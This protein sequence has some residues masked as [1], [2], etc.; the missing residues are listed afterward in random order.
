MATGAP[1]M[2]DIAGVPDDVLRAF[3]TR[4]Q[5][6]ET[7]LAEHDEA[8]PR[9]AQ[10]AALLTRR[11][12]DPTADPTS[13]VPAWRAKARALGFDADTIERLTGRVQPQPAPRPGSLEADAL[14]RDLAS[15]GGLTAHRST[16][17]RPDVIE[18]ICERLPA[19]GRVED[20]LA[21]ADGF[22]TS[23]RVLAVGVDADRRFHRGD[24]RA[25]PAGGAL[26]RWT[27]PEM[28]DC[29][30]QVLDLATRDRR[31]AA[32]YVCDETVTRAV[33][34]R[35]TLTAEQS[36]M[37]R[38]VCGSGRAV[39]V[40]EGVAGAGKTFALAVAHDAWTS[41]GYRV[42]GACLAARAARNLHDGAGIASTT[43]DRLLARIEHGD[44]LGVRDVVVVDEASMVGTRKL[45]RLLTAAHVAGA[46]VVLVG[47][48]R[49]LPEVEAGGAF[50]HL[51][52]QLGVPALID[53]RRQCEGWERHA[54]ATLRGGD[55]DEALAMYDARDR[56]HAG[57]SD[58][59]VRDQ[60]VADWLAAR[61]R[62][63]EVLMIASRLRDVDDLNSRA[64]TLLHRSG[65][66]GAAVAVIGGR[67]FAIGEQVLA[68]RN[69]HASGVLNGTRGTLRSVG[70]DS[71]S[72]AADG[73]R[74]TVPRHYAEAGHLA[75]GYAT[76]IHKAQ[77]TTVD[78]C[79]VLADDTLAQEHAY[80]AMSRG[81]LG[82]DLYVT[83]TDRRVDD[84]HAPEVTP[85]PLESLRAAIRRS[86]AERFAIDQPT[87]PPPSSIEA[88][89]AERDHLRAR[90]A[91][92]LADPTAKVEALDARV[93]QARQVLAAATSQRDQLAAVA[94]GG[95][96][97]RRL[98]R[99]SVAEAAARLP[100]AEKVVR[101]ATDGLAG[102]TASRAALEPLVRVW[103][104]DSVERVADQDRL[105]HLEL[106][107]R[108]AQPRAPGLE[109]SRGRGGGLAIGL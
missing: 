28:V 2:A 73:R 106:A 12:K 47:D 40:V 62:G 54:L 10:R 20:V 8:G 16:F 68:L 33:D 86:S 43:L 13:M 75:H 60:L 65:Q 109:R 53:N 99:Q 50:A 61:E 51:A 24:G 26:A 88:L 30:R 45:L 44:G 9:A 38:H 97:A 14:Y 87:E 108:L 49:Q 67:P 32:G 34:A 102:L 91:A 107:L 79:L 22:L 89:H 83:A 46:K 90:L 52:H 96:L 58:D 95:R 104:E 77:G 63:E 82:N 85:D 101:D 1:G 35:T 80:T 18:A 7:Y 69:D 76:T 74:L 70:R 93:E 48:P 59:E 11:R 31:I 64:R 56:V 72:I 98:H 66:L 15:A 19:G 92:K 29:E 21:L 25:M 6:I 41:A 23:E 36:A 39:D 27:T 81:R 100:A 37:V 57:G 78:R 55:T 4:R 17:S 42:H 105:R 3:S 71:L 94:G 103:Q 84:R 5:E